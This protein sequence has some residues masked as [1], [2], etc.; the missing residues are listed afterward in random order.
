MF[1]RAKNKTEAKLKAINMQPQ[2]PLRAAEHENW[3]FFLTCRKWT[4]AKSKPPPFCG[5]SR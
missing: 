4:G 5:S 1:A 2:A 3:N